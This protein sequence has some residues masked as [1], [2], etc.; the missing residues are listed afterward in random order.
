MT[1]EIIGILLA[2]VGAIITIGGTIANN[3]LLDHDLAMKI[4]RVSN[5]MM[6]AWALGLLA[7]WWNGGLSAGAL[8]IMYLIFV[9]TNEKGLSMKRR[10]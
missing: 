5:P 9:I 2:V 7:D 6:F 10:T 3:I 1:L 8:M 4:W